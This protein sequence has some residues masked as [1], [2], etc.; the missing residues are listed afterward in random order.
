MPE[1]KTKNWC[2]NLLTIIYTSITYFS[3]CWYHFYSLNFRTLGQ[4]RGDTVPDLVYTNEAGQIL[5]TIF[6][7]YKPEVPPRKNYPDPVMLSVNLNVMFVTSLDVIGQT[8]ESTVD[9]EVVSKTAS[10]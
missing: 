4:S 7:K 2:M 8:L 5:N 6:H 3:L 9:L 1:I 10:L